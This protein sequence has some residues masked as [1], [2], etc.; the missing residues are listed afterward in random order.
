LRHYKSL[1]NLHNQPKESSAEK[2]SNKNG[3]S[4]DLSKLHKNPKKLGSSRFPT[5]INDRIIS[6]EDSAKYSQL[7]KSHA[8][9]KKDE[10]KPKQMAK[11]NSSTY[12]K[13]GE[14]SKVL[15]PRNS[16]AFARKEV[17]EFEPL[18]KTQKKE[19]KPLKKEKG[20]SELNFQKSSSKPHH[21]ESVT[22]ERFERKSK[23]SHEKSRECNSHKK[24]KKKLQKM[25]TEFSLESTP[26]C[27]ISEE[28]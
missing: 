3:N 13:K 27:L 1:E 22:I 11:N 19:K 23:N 26:S 17:T 20:R 4:N 15:S 7:L 14:K 18:T 28:I 8:K 16:K 9:P 2:R 25:N 24:S 6:K 12:L 21:V 10:K 5:E